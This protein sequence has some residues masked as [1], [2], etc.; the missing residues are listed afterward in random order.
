M[1]SCGGFIYLVT[2]R[3]ALRLPVMS[4]IYC[5][6]LLSSAAADALEDKDISE[7]TRWGSTWDFGRGFGLVL[8]SHRL[9]VTIV[10]SMSL[11]C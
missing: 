1:C 9:E 3:E 7:A 4:H 2:E 11:P 10:V 8:Y 6:I 5:V